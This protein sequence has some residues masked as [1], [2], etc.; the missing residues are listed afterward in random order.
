MFGELERDT[1]TRK[2]GCDDG[3][4]MPKEAGKLKSLSRGAKDCPEPKEGHR[5][6]LGLSIEWWGIVVKGKGSGASLP[7]HSLGS[8]PYQPCDLKQVSHR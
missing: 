2:N 8:N 1:Q 7:E 3:F 6:M 5:P 4:G